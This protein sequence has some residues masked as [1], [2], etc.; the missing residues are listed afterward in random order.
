MK[1]LLRALATVFLLFGSSAIAQIKKQ[2]FSVIQAASDKGELLSVGSIDVSYKNFKDKANYPWGLTISIALDEK[3][4]FATKLPNKEESKIAT[5]LED[6]L[7]TKLKKMA[8]LQYV[9][10]IYYDG[11]LDVY[12][13]LKDPKAVN[14]YLS[15]TIKS[16]NF[17]R[18]FRYV[19]EQDPNW[20]KVSKYM[21]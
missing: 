3:N 10:H 16:Q 4:L 12:I 15:K 17:I 19:I 6:S 8:T 18:E 9:G 2:K 5:K 21:N 1:K 20:S 14:N 13:Y 7:T 11:F